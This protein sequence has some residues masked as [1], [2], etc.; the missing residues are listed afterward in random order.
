M[1]VLRAALIGAACVFH[2]ARA[3]ALPGEAEAA[4]VAAPPIRSAVQRVWEASP[5]VQAARA[6]VDAARAR[7]RA[8]AQPVYNPSLSLDAENADVDRRT[9]SLSLPL[10]MSGKRRARTSL[11]EA[12]QRSR[13]AS[14][15]LQRRDVASRWLK[16]WSSA[17]LA[18]RQRELGEHRVTLMRRFDA[19]AAER[20]AVGDISSPE[21]DLAALALGESQIQQASLAGGEA[22]ARAALEAVAGDEA[23]MPP[24]PAGLPPASTGIVPVALDDRPELLK[25]RADE[26]AAQA[27]I[28]VARR[29]R[30]HDPTVSL[31]GGRVNTG[32]R[33][34]QVI[35]LSVSI[36]LPVLNNGR[37]EIDAALAE[38]GAASAMVRARQ[39][40]TRASL[41]EAQSR[42]DA[43]LAAGQAFRAGRAAAFDDRTA[44]LE[45]LWRA[46][47]I[48]TSDYL[49]QL[50][51]SLDTALSALALESQA[52][53][54]WFDYLAAAGR[55]TDWLD[56][57]TQE[58]SP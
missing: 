2:V 15:E 32:V 35:G 36:P 49:V 37:A 13:E 55:L 31:T 40:V 24:L 45:K 58:A 1:S 50:K 34:D 53:Q 57:R 20:L 6:D 7:V 9:A 29:A 14:Y 21:R 46:G 39:Q 48:S 33:T 4:P 11:A 26:S 56:G 3:M 52:W 54:A 25:V 44:L 12:E 19:L 16:A 43:L 38:A 47:E 27:G 28:D 17:A 42:Y 8:A 5:E 41:R 23:A 22:A 18:A 30:L 10:D 51:Q